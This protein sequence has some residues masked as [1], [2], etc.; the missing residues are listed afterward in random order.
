[1]EVAD[2]RQQKPQR[3]ALDGIMKRIQ[4]RRSGFQP[5]GHDSIKSNMTWE[6]D[7]MLHDRHG[8][9]GGGRSSGLGWDGWLVMCRGASFMEGWRESWRTGRCDAALIGQ[10]VT[11]VGRNEQELI[12]QKNCYCY[13][14]S[15][16]RGGKQRLAGRERGRQARRHVGMQ[17]CRHKSLDSGPA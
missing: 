7:R 2:R 9:G 4:R 13:C 6:P 17:A 3:P 14:Y 1:M 5:R 10:I 11:F 8:F 12:L 16:Y 15:G